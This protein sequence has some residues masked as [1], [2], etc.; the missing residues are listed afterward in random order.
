M[1]Y[2]VAGA[3]GSSSTQSVTITTA[4]LAT[5]SYGTSPT[6]CVSGTTNPAP[7]FGTGASGGVFS[8]TTGLTISASTGVITLASSTPGTYTVTNT[9]AANGGCATATA[10]ATVTITAAPVATFSYGTSPTYCV[11][12]TTAPAVVLGMGATTGTFSSTTGLTVN[13]TTGAITLASSTPDTYTV[14]NSVPAANG[15]AATTATAQVTITAAPTATFSYPTAAGCVGSAGTA[16]PTLGAGASS[17]VFSSTTG[18]TIN[19][20]TGV[21]TLSSSTAGTYTVTNT[22]AANGGCAAA[23]ATTTFTVNPRP[24]TP[25]IGAAY[26]GTTTTL[27]SSAATGNQFYFNGTAITGATGQTYV[28]NGTPATLGSYTV[29][30]TNANGCVSLPSVPLVVTATKAGIAG[31]SLKLYPNPT[32]SGQV[33]LEL[34]GYRSATQLTVLDALGRVVTQQLLP[35]NAGTATHTLDL[36][37]AATGVYLLRLSNTDGVETRRL[38]RE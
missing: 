13:A 32:P 19:A 34:T 28:V 5:F 22:V 1:T 36:T 37:G 17:G 16:T 35:A 18:L 23:T 33:T 8:S 29:T 12:G 9:I 21:I 4:P 27:T 3:C 24:A 25:T 15:C 11:S 31:A 14:T 38:V 7:S 10:T 2:T 6:Y 30:T 26:N 20:S